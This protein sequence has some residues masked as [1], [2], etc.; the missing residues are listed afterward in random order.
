MADAQEEAEDITSICGGL[1]INI[2]TLNERTIPSMFLAGKKANQLGHPVILDPVGA[3]A[4]R[5]RTETALNIIKEV[6]VQVI[7][8]NMSEI[9]TYRM[10]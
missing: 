10:P 3:G 6:N 2:G 9:K 8:G 7:R 4:S 1:N 5:L